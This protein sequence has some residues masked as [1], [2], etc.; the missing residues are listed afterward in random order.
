MIQVLELEE[1]L[2]DT[3]EGTL[4]VRLET[5]LEGS[6][7]E[8]NRP[9]K[10]VTLVTSLSIVDRRSSWIGGEDVGRGLDQ[11]LLNLWKYIGVLSISLIPFYFSF[12]FI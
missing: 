1:R 10:V 11:P 12:Y 9:T 5:T 7:K 2:E 6:Q 4:I 8:T 3:L